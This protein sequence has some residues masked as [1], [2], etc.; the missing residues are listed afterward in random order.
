MRKTFFFL[1]LLIEA[2]PFLNLKRDRPRPDSENSTS[3]SSPLEI[4]EIDNHGSI[5]S[6]VERVKNTFSPSVKRRN[7]SMENQIIENAH[8][9]ADRI[10]N[11]GI[12]K[13]VELESDRTKQ[14]N[15][16]YDRLSRKIVDQVLQ[17]A[18]TSLRIEQEIR[19]E[20]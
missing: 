2:R 5:R 10:L 16:L 13:F 7:S 18:L 8:R 3:S 14:E 15:I 17:D 11:D 20:T 12:E 6:I 4:I 1:F 9:I 19:D